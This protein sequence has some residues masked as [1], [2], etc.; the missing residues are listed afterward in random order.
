MQRGR[1]VA[2]A[3]PREALSDARLADVFGIAVAQVDS[4]DGVMPV[5]LRPV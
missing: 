5:P 2:D 1:I 4:G 3:A